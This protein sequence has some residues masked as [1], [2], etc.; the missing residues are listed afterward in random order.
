MGGGKEEEIA[1]GGVYTVSIC[2][3]YICCISIANIFVNVIRDDFEDDFDNQAT[4][5]RRQSC[6]GNHNTIGIHFC[7]FFTQRTRFAFTWTF[8]HLFVD[9]SQ[10]KNFSFH[11]SSSSSLCFRFLLIFA[12]CLIDVSD[13]FF[14]FKLCSCPPTAQCVLPCP[15]PYPYHVCVVAPSLAINS[16]YSHHVARFYHQTIS[17]VLT[18]CRK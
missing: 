5:V 16:Q 1:V 3:A 17:Y 11:S 13:I 2:I 18:R 6:H 7:R 4:L 8:I 12:V 14:G 15:C 10:A 9:D